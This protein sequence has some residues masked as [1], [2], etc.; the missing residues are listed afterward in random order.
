LAT[1]SDAV[2]RFGPAVASLSNRPHASLQIGDR[3]VGWYCD[4][5][6]DISAIGNRQA[7][8]IFEL[9]ADY[10]AGHAEVLLRK[11]CEGITKWNN[12]FVYH[13][14][15]HDVSEVKAT[16]R[17]SDH[18][19]VAWILDFMRLEWRVPPLAGIFIPITCYH[20]SSIYANG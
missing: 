13:D 16:H 20:T 11:L 19:F 15:V 9:P 10:K 4:N 5:L 2:A 6:C 14:D 8:A 17:G 18:G 1:D 12:E 7:V 3:L